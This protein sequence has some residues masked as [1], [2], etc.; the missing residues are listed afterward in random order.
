MKTTVIYTIAF[1]IFWLTGMKCEKSREQ[2]NE[3]LPEATREG[4]NTFGFSLNGEVWIPKGA[5]LERKLDLSYDPNYNG[6]AMSIIAERNISNEDEQFLSI[7]GIGINKIGT[8]NF[9][10]AMK[11]V[12]YNDRNCVYNDNTTITGSI[13]ITR[14][15]LAAKIISGTFSFKLEKN[16]CPTINATDG[17]FD[18]RIE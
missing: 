6:G 17:R 11:H 9:T 12:Y 18:M 1:F 7:G 16:G 2:A 8:Y 3:A 4:K 10:S 15:D 14:L 5:L 13:T